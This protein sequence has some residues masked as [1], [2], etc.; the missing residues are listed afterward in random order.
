VVELIV[1][2]QWLWRQSASGL[3]AEAERLTRAAFE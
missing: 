1:V 3:V 2:D